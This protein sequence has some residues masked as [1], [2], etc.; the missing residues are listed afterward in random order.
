MSLQKLRCAFQDTLNPDVDELQEQI[1]PRLFSWQLR[2]E[3]C[4][5]LFCMKSSG[6]Q[7][8]LKCLKKNLPLFN[9][10]DVWCEHRLNCTWNICILWIVATWLDNCTHEPV[11]LLRCP[12]SVCYVFFRTDFLNRWSL[13]R[14]SH[15]QTHWYAASFTH[16]C[17]FLSV[18]SE[19]TLFLSVVS[20]AIIARLTSLRCPLSDDEEHTCSFTHTHSCSYTRTLHKESIDF[21]HR[22]CGI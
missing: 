16:K 6:D 7:Q 18:T 13:Q 10:S 15:H 9:I 3:I 1:T 8:I 17:C 19:Q 2:T 21:A 22:V 20:G 14:L 4:Q 12:V 5:R 11:L